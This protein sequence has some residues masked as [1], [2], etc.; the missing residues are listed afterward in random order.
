MVSGLVVL[1]SDALRACGLGGWYRGQLYA[2]SLDGQGLSLAVS[3]QRA[4][5]YLSMGRQAWHPRLHWV[6]RMTSR[7]SR[8][9]ACMG[10]VWTVQV[11]YVKVMQDSADAYA[12]QLEAFK[13][14]IKGKDKDKV[15]TTARWDDSYITNRESCMTIRI[16]G[17]CGGLK[18]TP[19]EARVRDPSQDREEPTASRVR[20]CA[21]GSE[22]NGFAFFY[23]VV[24]V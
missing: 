15:S 19:T 16:Y 5:N 2:S 21:D 23:V 1:L 8:L 12:K 24:C 10:V 4:L 20:P 7:V 18:S 14:A 6:T 3:L 9:C 17:R 13:K 22:L 11:S